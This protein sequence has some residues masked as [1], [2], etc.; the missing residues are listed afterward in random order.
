MIKQRDEGDQTDAQCKEQDAHQTMKRLGEDVFATEGEDGHVV[1]SE[2]S[3]V[4]S[5][6]RGVRS[7]LSSLNLA[8][9]IK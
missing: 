9:F 6:G 2:W 4:N 1:S 7:A 3:M 5:E 8:S